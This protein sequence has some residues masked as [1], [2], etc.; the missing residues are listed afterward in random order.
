MYV[1]VCVCVCVFVCVCVCV[2]VSVF[3]FILYLYVYIYSP[4]FG[5][6][7]FLKAMNHIFSWTRHVYK[8]FATWH[9]KYWLATFLYVSQMIV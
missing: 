7:R 8:H 3:L 5:L 1:C 9:Y 6:L 4:V 2:C